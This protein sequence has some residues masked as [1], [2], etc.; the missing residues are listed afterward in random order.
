MW[1]LPRTSHWTAT[2]I[3]DAGFEIRDVITHLFGSGFPKSMD[4]SRA[5]DKMQGAER[6]VIGKYKHPDG[7][8]RVAKANNSGNCYGRDGRDWEKDITAP[9]TTEAQ[10]YSG[11]G[12]AL[13]PANEHWILARKPISEKSI[14]ENVLRWNGC[15]A[16]NIAATRVGVSVEDAQAMERANTPGS[17]RFNPY[18]AQPGGFGRK[19]PM[20]PYNTTQGRFPSNLLLSHSVWCIPIGTKRVR[21]NGRPNCDGK[22]YPPKRDVYGQ[23]GD[24]TYQAHYTDPDGMETIE[25]YECHESCPIAELDRQSGVRK[26]GAKHP[27]PDKRYQ[28]NTYGLG[29]TS[30]IQTYEPNEGGASRYFSQF[31]PDVPVPYRYV[32]KASRTERNTGCEGLPEKTRDV[33]STFIGTPEHSP[34]TNPPAQNSHPCVKPL[35]LCQWLIRLVTPPGGIVLDCFAGSGSTLVAAI[36]EGVHFIGIEQDEAYCAIAESRIAYAFKETKSVQAPQAEEYDCHPSCPIRI[37]GEQSGERPPA[38]RKNP[39]IHGKSAL[40][41]NGRS[42]HIAGERGYK[43]TGTAARYFQQFAFDAF[44]EHE[45]GK[46]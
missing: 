33:Y 5:I 31:S 40:F 29:R 37:L 14:A 11:Y 34:K 16:L 26:S 46:A 2:A 38:Y 15:G 7:G 10:R 1:A 6:E 12:T 43:D 23:Y 24:D 30:G 3:E 17:Q 32:S 35:A 41:G 45:E 13:K 39:S 44:A 42:D 27:Y 9:A 18:R 8:D 22:V 36:H 19:N 28:T 20:E 25:A 4:I 21:A